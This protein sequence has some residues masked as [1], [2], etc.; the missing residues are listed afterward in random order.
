MDIHMFVTFIEERL[1]IRPRLITSKELRLI[2]DGESKTGYKLCYLAS[3]QTPAERIF[4]LAS[5]EVA[6]E[7]HQVGL[8][9]HQCQFRALSPEMMKELSVRGFNDMRTILLT[10]DKRMLGIIL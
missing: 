1:G 8:G 3:P 5:G 10:H 9:L 7:I 4:T 2:P 6:E